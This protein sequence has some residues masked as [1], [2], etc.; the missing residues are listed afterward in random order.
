MAIPGHQDPALRRF[1][2]GLYEELWRQHDRLNLFVTSKADEI[3]RRLEHL[4]G[5][6]QRWIAKSHESRTPSRSL[7]QHRKFVKH[8]RELLRC[9]DDIQALVRFVNA[10]VVAFRKILKK[11]KVSR[12]LHAFIDGFH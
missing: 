6:L 1:E 4:A 7:K 9:N 8:E 12:A 5:N 3:S 10:Q 2:D 11:Y